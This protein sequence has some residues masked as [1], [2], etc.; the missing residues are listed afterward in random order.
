MTFVLQTSRLTQLQSLPHQRRNS[1]TRQPH[2][3]QI[4]YKCKGLIKIIKCL[5]STWWGTDPSSLLAVYRALIRNSIEYGAIAIPYKSTQ[6]KKIEVLQ[7]KPLRLALGHRNS[8][9]NN[10]ILAEA[11][12]PTLEARLQLLADKFLLRPSLVAWHPLI[13]SLPFLLESLNRRNTAVYIRAFPLL[14]PLLRS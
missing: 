8:D 9:P 7:C 12:E 13:T 11:G 6:F 10:L 2:I 5:R 14:R 4:H 1:L 3:N